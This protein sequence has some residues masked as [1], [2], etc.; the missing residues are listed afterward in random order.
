MTRPDYGRSVQP[1]ADVRRDN[2]GL[3]RPRRLALRGARLFD[4]HRTWVGRGPGVLVEGERIVAVFDGDP[5]RDADLVDLAG[6]TLLPG[7][8]DAHVHLAFD[9][10][11]DPVAALTG[12]DDDDARAAMVKAARVALRGGVT[13]VRD[14]GDRGYLSLDL[15]G[16]ADLPTIVAAGPPITTPL[17]HCHFLGGQVADSADAVRAAVREHADRGCDLVKVMSS[18]GAMTPGTRMEEAQFAR[19]VLVAAVHEAHR[20]GLPVTAHA[21]GSAAI[22]DCLAAGVDGMEH[23]SF[24][25]ADGVDDRADLRQAIADAGIAVGATVGMLSPPLGVTPPPEVLARLPRMFANLRDL[26]ERGAVVVAGTDAGIAP[27][28]PHDVLRTATAQL[29]E[30]GLPP[31]DALRTV[32]SI[33]ARVVGLGHR[34]GRLAPGFDADVL[35]VDGDPLSD[36]NA[37]HRVRA[38]YARGQAVAMTV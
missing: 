8:V 24:W 30:L 9:A 6:A 25:A 16:R 36:P 11:P 33:A 12:R 35:V 17:G 3:E 37:I 28:K 38:V 34:K 22:E 5:P 10:S 23:V 21:H 26:I 15:R 14:L 18:G 13:T 31:L 29:G 27:V 1:R 19:A 20:L 2:A 32:T 7:L 4:G